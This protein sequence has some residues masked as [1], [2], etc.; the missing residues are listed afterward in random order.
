MV[1][2][3]A[4]EWVC[5]CVRVCECACVC[6][7]ECVHMQTHSSSKSSSHFSCTITTRFRVLI[8]PN[9]FFALS[10][11]LKILIVLQMN[12]V[13][14]KCLEQPSFSDCGNE[15]Q[16]QL[17]KFLNC[18]ISSMSVRSDM[19]VRVWQEKILSDCRPLQYYVLPKIWEKMCQD[20]KNK[21]RIY[22]TIKV[23][24]N[25]FFLNT[26]WEQLQKGSSINDVT[27]LKR[28]RGQG[29]FHGRSL[30]RKNG[31][32]CLKWS[33]FLLMKKYFKSFKKKS[34]YRISLKLKL[35]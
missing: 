33:N 34:K 11:I 32:K 13:S 7:C 31:I 22:H 30:G 27:C 24:L 26:S 20:R 19:S 12:T 6:V 29:F 18:L 21:K 15:D 2:E 9:T 4:Y 17:D 10:Y 3:I 1:A 5:E 16:S 8:S 25:Q 28:G 23:A 35:M 14:H